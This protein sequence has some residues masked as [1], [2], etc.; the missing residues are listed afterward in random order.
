VWW[1]TGNSQLVAD[2]PCSPSELF[3]LIIAGYTTQAMAT[4]H[5]EQ[6]LCLAVQTIF[7]IKGKDT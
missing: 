5:E 6:K 3:D 1:E 7:P 4:K 2:D